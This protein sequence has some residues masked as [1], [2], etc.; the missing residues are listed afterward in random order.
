MKLLLKILL[1]FFTWFNLSATPA[2]SKVALPDYAVSFPKIASQS[3][4]SEL[5]IGVSNFARSGISENL[6]SQK[7][8]LWESSVLE[9]RAREGNIKIV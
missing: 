2:F 4:E 8:V 6:F 7:A 1:I 3:L 5:K 9:N